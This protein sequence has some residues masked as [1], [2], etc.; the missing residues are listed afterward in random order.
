[1]AVTMMT[2]LP[3]TRL[4][5]TDFTVPVFGFGGIPVG[6]DSLGVERPTAV[7]SCP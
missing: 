2:D 4:G 6:R 3:T 1:M 7:G 5:R